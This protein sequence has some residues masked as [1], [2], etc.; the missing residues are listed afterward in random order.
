[1]QRY[2]LSSLPTTEIFQQQCRPWRSGTLIVFG[3]PFSDELLLVAIRQSLVR[4]R[5]ALDRGMEM[6]D[7]QNCYAP[8]TTREQQVVALVV[9]GL[10]NKQIGAELGIS[11]ITIKAHRGT[12]HAE[13]EGELFRC[14]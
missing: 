6:R 1:V 3:K 14:T 5:A 2:L 7:L 13:D 10:L 11:E 4:S 9:S 12:G 8:L